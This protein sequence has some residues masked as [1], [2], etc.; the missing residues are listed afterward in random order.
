MDH[1]QIFNQIFDHHILKLSKGIAKMD[2]EEYLTGLLPSTKDAHT[3]SPI[4][5]EDKGPSLDYKMAQAR[6]H[7]NVEPNYETEA[8][9]LEE[10][11][12]DQSLYD[13]ASKTLKASVVMIFY[14]LKFK[15]NN[16]FSCDTLICLS[17]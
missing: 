17:L 1:I 16:S 2:V 9:S 15:K 13:S 5:D 6:R 3:T 7:M 12:S 4:F 14:F 11:M 8:Y 10:I